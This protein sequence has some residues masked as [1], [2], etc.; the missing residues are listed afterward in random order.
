VLEGLFDSA[1]NMLDDDLRP[2]PYE[3]VRERV[4]RCIAERYA[5]AVEAAS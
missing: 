4:D 1:A 3:L 5:R 2:V